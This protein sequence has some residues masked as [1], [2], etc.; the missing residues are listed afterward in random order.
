MTLAKVRSLAS[1]LSLGVGGLLVG[2]GEGGEGGTAG[3]VDVDA[4]VGVLVCPELAVLDAAAEVDGLAGVGLC[5]PDP[6]VEDPDGEL[7]GGDV[8]PWVDDAS[9]VDD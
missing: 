2:T 1:A 9:F 7:L 3:S 5:T 8:E 6:A 4:A